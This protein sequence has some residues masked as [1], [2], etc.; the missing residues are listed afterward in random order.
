M[1]SS[2]GQVSI[3]RIRESGAWWATK[4]AF[5]FLVL[6][7]TRSGEV[8]G[9]CWEEV[10][11]DVW[12]VPAERTKTGR[13]H[14]VPLSGRALEVLAETRE[15]TGGEGLIL[16]AR[17]G[18]MMSDMTISKL[19]KQRGIEAVPHGFRSRL[20]D[21]A[22]E[23]T[24]IPREIAEHALAHVVGDAAELVYRRTDYFDKR[25]TLMDAWA[26]YL[27]A[28]RADVRRIA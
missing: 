22:A 21:W 27:A 23:R 26:R 6:T 11:G 17:R 7:A 12:T 3:A 13:V 5:E 18:G 25:R 15:R 2:Q 1:T 10:D 16:P 8:P 20:R 14:R 9:A 19:V 24:N 4:A 28:E